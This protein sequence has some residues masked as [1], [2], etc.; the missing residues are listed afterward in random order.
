MGFFRDFFRGRYGMDRFNVFLFIVSIVLW[1]ILRIVTLFV[2]FYWI[3]L[4]A[5]LPA[6]YAIF[7]ALSRS[8]QK[9]RIEN[10]RYMRARQK[11]LD[12][13][14]NIKQWFADRKAYKYF[15]CPK[16][17]A[18]LRVP[19]MGGKTLEVTCRNCGNKFR[20]KS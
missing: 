19:R 3:T 2:G 11:F 1:V 4:I 20:V 8:L 18:K 14:R 9:R 5:Y 16:C 7:R 15:Y 13:F 17:R 12:F 10:E 6:I